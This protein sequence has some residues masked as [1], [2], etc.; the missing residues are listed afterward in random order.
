MA[1]RENR[2]SS[3]E[4]LA[5]VAGYA[6]IRVARAGTGSATWLEIPGAG[7]SLRVYPDQISAYAWQNGERRPELFTEPVS[8][9]LR[10]L[11]DMR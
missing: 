6:L 2:T 5:L 11:I 9:W 4:A 1:P 3:E 10:S 7:H 8:Q